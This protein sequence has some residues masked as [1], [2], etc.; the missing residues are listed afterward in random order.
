MKPAVIM[1]CFIIVVCQRGLAKFAKTDVYFKQ[2]THLELKSTL[3]MSD[4]VEFSSSVSV[5]HEDQIEKDAEKAYRNMSMEARVLGNLVTGVDDEEFEQVWEE[6]TPKSDTKN[7]SKSTSV[8][9][10]KDEVS[11]KDGSTSSDSRRD[12]LGAA[13]TGIRSPSSL[14]GFQTVSL[15]ALPGSRLRIAR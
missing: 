14:A 13:P 2:I 12:S 4:Q 8:T 3:Q 9:E 7:Y 10:T 15:Q 1:V 6:E 5:E 11:V